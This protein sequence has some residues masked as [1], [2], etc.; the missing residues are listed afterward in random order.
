MWTDPPAALPAGGPALVNDLDLT[1]TRSGDQASTSGES[2]SG[3]FRD[4]MNN[5]ERVVV[6]LGGG[7][8][9]SGAGGFIVRV[10]GRN[11]RWVPGGTR[12]QPYALV[13]TA[14]GLAGAPC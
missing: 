12:G 9:E 7:R 3:N 14:P 2:A 1:V 6:D 4:D 11:V 5:V 8:G 10:I 13:A